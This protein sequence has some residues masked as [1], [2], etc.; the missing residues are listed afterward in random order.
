MDISNLP[1]V[2]PTHDLPAALPAM[3][4]DISALATAVPVLNSVDATK[5][6]ARRMLS[7]HT[8]E[9]MASAGFY[10]GP[11]NQWIGAPQCFDTL[12][13]SNLFNKRHVPDPLPTGW[14]WLMRGGQV[15]G[16]GDKAA[17]SDGRLRIDKWKFTFSADP[18]QIDCT[19][20]VIDI[21]RGASL[22]VG[23]RA[24]IADDEG[25]DMLPDMANFRCCIIK[26]HL[27]VRLD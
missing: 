1:T 6:Q 11:D 2:Q 13:M 4:V 18:V 17:S 5:Q 14:R 21:P 16:A 23:S 27:T 8:M 15:T 20:T 9:F 10:M 22:I 24:M 19:V 7:N 26:H 12:S 25:L 3:E